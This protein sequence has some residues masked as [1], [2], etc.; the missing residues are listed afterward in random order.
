MNLKG[1]VLID[2]GDIVFA[3]GYLWSDQTC[4]A[5]TSCPCET[6]SVDRILMW[7]GLSVCFSRAEVKAEDESNRIHSR[8]A[9]SRRRNG[10]SR[11][12][13]TAGA[14]LEPLL[15]SGL[16]APWSL[17][18]LEL[19]SWLNTCCGFGSMIRL[20]VIH[21][22]I[23]ISY[24][25]SRTILYSG[26]ALLIYV[27]ENFGEKSPFRRTKDGLVQWLGSRMPHN[28]LSRS[29]ILDNKLT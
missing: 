27:T 14:G 2:L 26:I 8:L 15:C 6:F 11:L 7:R 22:D 23:V 17:L 10:P 1:S 18:R 19:L 29:S 4:R 25:L 28:C 5:R 24:Q 16:L 20:G 21:L 12:C 13:Y 9:W 3:Y